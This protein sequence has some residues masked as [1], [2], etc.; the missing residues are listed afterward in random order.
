MVLEIPTLLCD[1]TGVPLSRR[2]NDL[3]L[4]PDSKNA[5]H[6]FRIN[7]EVPHGCHAVVVDGVLFNDK[8]LATVFLKFCEFAEQIFA[9]FRIAN[10]FGRGNLLEISIHNREGKLIPIHISFDCELLCIAHGFLTALQTMPDG[11]HYAFAT[12]TSRNAR[13]H[14]LRFAILALGRFVFDLMCVSFELDEKITNC[15]LDITRSGNLHDSRDPIRSIVL[16]VLAK[17][18]SSIGI[19]F[20]WEGFRFVSC[21]GDE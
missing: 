16:A 7:E 1:R 11:A 21:T 13:E 17:L 3:Y 5:F 14:L 18:E 4:N 19:N 9:T 6:I 2:W 10:C 20:L 8:N 12:Q 15:L